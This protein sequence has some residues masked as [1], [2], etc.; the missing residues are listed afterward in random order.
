MIRWGILGTGAVAHAFARDLRLVPGAV[1]SAVGSR[2][3]ETGDPFAKAY[4]AKHVHVGAASL[5]SDDQVDV[6]YVATPHTSHRDD[7]L[8]CLSAGRAVLVEKPF[9]VN[10]AEARAVVEQARRSKVFCME[11]MWMRCHPL[12]QQVHAIVQSGKLGSIRLLTAD[13]GYPASFDPESRFYNRE[14]GGGAL[15]DRGVYLLSLASLLLGPPDEVLGRAVIGSTGVDEQESLLLT[16]RTGAQAVLTA[17]LRS[18]LRNEAVIVGTEGEIRIHAPFYAP[19][20]VSW[21]PFREPVGA[22]APTSP[23]PGGWKAQIKHNPLFRRAFETIGRPL[24][25]RLR[26]K[27]K[28]FNH[29]GPGQGYQFEAA[30]VMRCLRS[31]LLESPLVS[32]DETVAIL[33]TTDRLTQSWITNHAVVESR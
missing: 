26:G 18:R 16:Y 4:G 11:A 32:L 20:R 7:A 9:T 12:I 29:Y 8:A 17:S 24:L 6:I 13:F 5:A 30:E 15:L 1:L 22:T 28:S 10:A 21:T 23:G 25:D 14:L 27:T 19:Y 31:G 33:E 3:H 2:R